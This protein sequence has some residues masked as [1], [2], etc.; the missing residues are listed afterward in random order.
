[1]NVPT[2]T[3]LELGTLCQSEKSPVIIDVRTPV[4]FREVHA[5]P[6]RNGPFDQLSPSTLQC[7][8]DGH[9]NDP[10]YFICRSGSRGR[11]ACEKL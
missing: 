6:A 7:A 10:I 4:E 5:E 3:A 11:Q 8:E 2:I 1:M 9:C